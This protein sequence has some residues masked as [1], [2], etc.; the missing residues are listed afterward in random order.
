MAV[1]DARAIKIVWRELAAH[2]V[3][4]QD[5]NAEAPHLAR[6][7]AE[8]HVV[9]VELH[10]EHRIGQRLDHLALEFDLVLLGHPLQPTSAQRKGHR[11]RGGQG[12]RAGAA[13]AIARGAQCGPAPPVFPCPPPC[14]RCPGALAGGPAGG[15]PPVSCGPPPS[16]PPLLLLLGPGG[17]LSGAGARYSLRPV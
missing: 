12:E 15:A 11:A 9:V 5:A 2:A 1:D 17:G 14:L 8:H 16:W 4:G 10:A 6:D 3:P 7:V 13:S